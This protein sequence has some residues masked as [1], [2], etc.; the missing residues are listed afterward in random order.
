VRVAIANAL[1]LLVV[2]A[3]CDRFDGSNSDDQHRSQ[4]RTT[5]PDTCDPPS[6][7]LPCD[8]ISLTQR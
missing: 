6:V 1:R 4:L 2:D 5:P 8:H 3:A 7:E